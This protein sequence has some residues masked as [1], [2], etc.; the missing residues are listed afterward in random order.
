M[1]RASELSAAITSW[2]ITGPRSAPVVVLLHA[3]A[4]N[5][6]LWAPQIPVWS[7][8]FRVLSVDLPGHGESEAQPRIQSLEAY[9]AAL[10]RLLTRESIATASLVGLSL[11]GMIA[12]AFALMF[13]ERVRALALCNT[14]ARTPPQLREVWS[15]RKQ[16]ALEHGMASQ[17]SATLERW[18][19]PSFARSSP[20]HVARIA[21]MIERTSVEGYCSAIEAIQRLDLL[22]ELPRLEMPALVVAGRD[23]KAATPEI[24]REIAARLHDARLV[25]LDDAAHLSNV[26]QP[27][28]FTETVGAF[29]DATLTTP[30]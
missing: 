22:D 23:D 17:V 2:R 16:A 6:E 4:T 30:C 9:A 10:E 13:P 21:R 29:L 8:R 19:T 24:A 20:L 3:I 28:A 25:I 5:L 26:E 27:V 14:S 11:G 12:Q 7:T 18:F 1:A 15:Q